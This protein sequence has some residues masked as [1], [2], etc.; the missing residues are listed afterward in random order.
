MKSIILV[1]KGF[2]M[3]I[4]NIIPGVSG[5]TLALTLGI[6]EDFINAISHFFADFK[7]NIKFLIPV[8][9][10]MGLSLATMSNV[11]S[12]SLKNFPLPTALFFMGL[13]IGG[14][15]ML[16]GKVKKTKD[17][18]K[19]SSYIIA[20]LTF[21]LVMMLTFSNELFGNGLGLVDLNNLT[22]LGYVVLFLVGIVAAAT[23]VIPGISGSLVL[24]LLGYYEP[25][26]DT[27]KD[28]T[29][30]NNIGSNLI[31]CVV[32]GL[33]VLIGLVLV[34]KLLEWL[35]KKYEAKTYFGVIGFILASVIAIPVSVLREVPFGFDIILEII[36]L[37]LFMGGYI[38]G[39]KLGEK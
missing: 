1:I 25:V 34:A 33:G 36:A 3:G 14:I 23:M 6:Y 16:V 5:G 26:V 29:H 19:V 17:I 30:F 21:G 8:F 15:P 28:L 2:I 37:V 22:V 20:L 35:F 13:V 11:I 31:I 9:I 39:N 32:F 12:Y 27:I 18:K 38:I 4:A 7:K 24:M 10:G